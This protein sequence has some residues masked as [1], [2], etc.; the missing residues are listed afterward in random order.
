[1]YYTP[2]RPNGTPLPDRQARQYGPFALVKVNGQWQLD[3]WPTGTKVFPSVRFPVKGFTSLRK[4]AKALAPLPEWRFTNINL[5]SSQKET[6]R[7]SIIDALGA[8]NAL[9]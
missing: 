6:L 9:P 1:M 8:I 2:T 4:L 7:Q 5:S 3:H